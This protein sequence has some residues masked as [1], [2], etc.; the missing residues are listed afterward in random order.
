MIKKLIKLPVFV[1][2]NHFLMRK[3]IGIFQKK[4]AKKFVIKKVN[5]FFFNSKDFP[6]ST[7]LVSFYEAVDNVRP[8]LELKTFPGAKIS[9]LPFEIS[10]KRQIFLAI[11]FFIS[12]CKHSQ[13]N[14]NTSIFK[15][16]LQEI[17]FINKF[18]GF[19]L[20][21][22]QL[23]YKNVC[24]SKNKIF[25]RNKMFPSKEVLHSQGKYKN[26]LNNFFF[27]NL[28]NFF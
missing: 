4:G 15:A 28:K 22:K 5:F 18:E 6:A 13:K 8:F 20:K 26:D 17:K 1:Y 11:N 10:Y 3:F 21:K 16:L 25:W 14:K 2:E 7:F 9:H 24:Q 12:G 27:K 19:S 23:L